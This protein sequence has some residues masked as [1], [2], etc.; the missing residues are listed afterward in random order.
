MELSDAGSPEPYPGLRSFRKSESDIFFGR[1]DHL[2]EMIVKLSDHYFLC[3]TGP[4]GCGKSSLARTGLMNHLE[5]GFLASRGSDWIFC[6]L[7]PGDHP[8]DNLFRRLAAAIAAEVK[9]DELA[10]AGGERSEQ[11]FQLFYTT[12][13]RRTSDLN[14]VIDLIAGVGG[15]PIMILVD[16]F[17]ELFRYAL[18]DSD[19]AVNFVEILKTLGVPRE[20][21]W[22]RVL[23]F[24][25]DVIR[26]P[27]TQ[28]GYV[29]DLNHSRWHG[30][31]IGGSS[32]ATIP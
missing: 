30:P 8:I 2:D 32:S 19:A 13:Q 31:T 25:F 28:I 4:S 3:I 20:K 9:S 12:T 22:Q 14:E 11:I 6:D 16:Q 24:L 18:S 7:S 29:Y 26:I 23:Y 17:E 5:A 1:D 27:Y 10:A 21:L 15:R